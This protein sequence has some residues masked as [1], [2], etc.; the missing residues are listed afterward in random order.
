M[1]SKKDIPITP[2]NIMKRIALL[3]ISFFITSISLAQ[4]EHIRNIFPQGTVFHQNIS[5]AGDT[6]KKHLLDIYLPADK[7]SARPLIVWLHGGA[8]MLNDKYADMSYMTKTIRRMTESGYALASIDYRHS[9]TAVFP[10]QIHDC[11]RAIQFLY[12]NAEKYGFDRQRFILIGFSA[13]GHLASLVALSK[14]ND[15]A[16]FYPEMKKPTFNVKAVLDF[17]GPADLMMFYANALPGKDESPI[18]KL[19]GVSPIARPD[20]AKMASP[21]TYI[22]KNDPPFFIVHGENDDAVPQTQAHLMKSWLDVAGVR[23]ELLIVKD[24][25]HYGEAFDTADV[26]QKL[27]AFLESVLK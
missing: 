16:A 3:F 26:Q 4:P 17:Y 19:L 20:V 7:K 22:D 2:N 21:I 14:N 6:L 11:A 23:N 5:Y 25:P 13:G 9:T 12:D 27:F 10:A 18:A 15:V 24:A 8:W 1:A